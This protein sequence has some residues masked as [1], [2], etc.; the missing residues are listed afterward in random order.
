MH[1]QRGTKRIYPQVEGIKENL[2]T[3]REGFK[4]NLYIDTGDCLCLV[5]DDNW[6]VLRTHDISLVQRL[7]YP[8]Q[9]E[10]NQTFN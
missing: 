7:G 6:M 1:R 4:E 3:D 10:E 2:S 8:S 5:K 9:N